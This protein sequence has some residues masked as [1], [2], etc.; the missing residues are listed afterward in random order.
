MRLIAANIYVGRH[1]HPSAAEP[2]T[3]TLLDILDADG[4]E[5][6]LD[7]EG[8]IAAFTTPVTLDRFPTDAVTALS[9]SN[10]V[11]PGSWL[12]F[13]TADITFRVKFV[14]S[15]LLVLDNQKDRIPNPL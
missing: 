3:S 5:A 9:E 6:R 12:E 10:L 14:G 15:N 7:G 11:R 13:E 8:A 1:R 2:W 4:L